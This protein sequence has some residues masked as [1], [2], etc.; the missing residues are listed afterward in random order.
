MNNISVGKGNHKIYHKL[1]YIKYLPVSYFG[2]RGIGFTYSW[3][4]IIKG[5]Y[6]LKY[7]DFLKYVLSF[8]IDLVSK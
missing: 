6:I 1:P 4:S 3:N 5:L 7:N 2:L 8:F